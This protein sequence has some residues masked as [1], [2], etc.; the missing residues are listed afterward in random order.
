MKKYIVAIIAILALVCCDRN[1]NNDSPKIVYE[2]Y[3]PFRYIEIRKDEERKWGMI[4]HDGKILFSELFDDYHSVMNE[5]GNIEKIFTDIS[6]A[7]N[8]LFLMTNRENRKD[9]YTAEKNPKF[10]FG[11]FKDAGIFRE[12]IAPT[13]K[14]G[15]WIKFINKNGEVEFDFKEVNGI[16]VTG[17]S[18]FHNGVAIFELADRTFGCIDTKGDIVIPPQE[19]EISFCKNSD[20]RYVVENGNI[21]IGNRIHN[22]SEKWEV[23]TSDDNDYVYE[24]CSPYS[25]YWALS[26]GDYENEI[27]II[28]DAKGKEV[29]RVK[30]EIEDLSGE[31]YIF[32]KDDKYGIANISG[33]II[34]PPSYSAMKFID[35]DKVICASER[36]VKILDLSGKLICQKYSENSQVVVINNLGYSHFY[37]GYRNNVTYFKG[38]NQDFSFIDNKGFQA[39]PGVFGD[40]IGFDDYLQDARKDY[41]WIQSDY[42]DSESIVKR[43]KLTNTSVCGA[44][45]N[46]TLED[47]YNRFSNS[48]MSD[49]VRNY[50][51][52]NNMLPIS[53]D[54]EG[55]SLLIKVYFSFDIWPDYESVLKEKPYGLEVII[56]NDNF[57]KDYSIN[58]TSNNNDNTKKLF[59]YLYN[60]YCSQYNITR[61]EKTEKAFYL[62]IS[63]GNDVN[64]VVVFQNAGQVSIAISGNGYQF[65][66]YYESIK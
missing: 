57:D 8:G 6:P 23:T 62:K 52:Q 39:V 59:E 31:N 45:A 15:E 25:D 43:I 51:S 48:I 49:G 4:R 64:S 17:V 63:R 26:V 5:D 38:W 58:G 35:Y 21:I 46:N 24:I 10:K 50:I 42:F 55:V 54:V 53:L 34:L 1:S 32:V 11:G 13:V 47:F 20:D 7:L 61:K 40:I 2:E 18:N 14:D 60:Y 65:D 3:L 28:Y 9:Y 16:N 27:C 12:N 56:T 66:S 22:L 36:E 30:A 19:E 29:K 41:E 37:R 44:G 33:D